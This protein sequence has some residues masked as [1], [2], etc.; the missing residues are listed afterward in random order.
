MHLLKSDEMPLYRDISIIRLIRQGSRLTTILRMNRDEFSED[1]DSPYFKLRDLMFPKSEIAFPTVDGTM[2]RPKKFSWHLIKMLRYAKLEYLSGNPSKWSIGE[3]EQLRF[4]VE[5]QRFQAILSGAFC[6]WCGLRP[7]EVATLRS[8][9]VHLR[10]KLV[11]LRDTKSGTDQTSALPDEMHVA[12]ACYCSHLGRADPL[13]VTRQGR[14]WDAVHVR[15]AIH[16]IGLELGYEALTPRRLRTSVG[17]ALARAG[18]HISVIQLQLRHKDPG[19]SLKYYIYT[20]LDQ[21][22]QALNRLGKRS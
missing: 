3:F 18:E 9:D 8:S 20:E 17:T 12:L 7:S 5:R 19:T 11:R 10:E 13:F 22:R 4:W 1:I 21:T 2:L 14:M 16:R 6:G 15:E